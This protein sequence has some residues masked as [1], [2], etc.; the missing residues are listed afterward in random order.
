MR[1]SDQ[2]QPKLKPGQ[3]ADIRALYVCV[4][5]LQIRVVDQR[6]ACLDQRADG[7]VMAYEGLSGNVTADLP[8]DADGL[9]IDYPQNFRRVYPA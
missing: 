7:M 2:C 4:P 9:V 3:R 8:L 1:D 5:S 6:Y